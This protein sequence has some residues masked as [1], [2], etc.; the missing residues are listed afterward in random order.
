MISLS[1]LSLGFFY[2]KKDS[3][4]LST[5]LQ[6]NGFICLVMTLLSND[7][8]NASS[9]EIG[10]WDDMVHSS[11]FFCALIFFWQMKDV[12]MIVFTFVCV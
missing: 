10:V 7:I 9:S 3:R 11:T 5:R 1:P 12:R 8:G 4:L 6:G 2:M